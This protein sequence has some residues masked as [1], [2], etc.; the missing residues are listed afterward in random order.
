MLVLACAGALASGTLVLPAPWLSVAGLRIGLVSCQALPLI[1]PVWPAIAWIG[2][3]SYAIYLF[4]VFFTA[5]LRDAALALAPGLDP[6]IVWPMGVVAGLLG[7][8]LLHQAIL[9][10]R[11]AAHL[12]LG[13][14]LRWGAGGQGA[15]SAL[16]A[17]AT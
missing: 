14:S 11:I 10:N 7:P 5:G 15:R 13:L 9:H 1:R 16:V 3:R 17:R 12:L 8:I 6:G 2:Q 4:H